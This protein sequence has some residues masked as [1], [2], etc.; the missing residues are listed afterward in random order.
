V[1]RNWIGDSGRAL[2]S[3]CAIFGALQ[4]AADSA[5][6][7]GSLQREYVA[8]T[9]STDPHTKAL[10]AFRMNDLSDQYAHLLNEKSGRYRNPIPD[11]HHLRSLYAADVK[12]ANQY[13][14]NITWCEVNGAWTSASQGY[15]LYL[16]LW[17]NGPAAD[18]AWWRGKFHN[19]IDNCVDAAGTEDETEELIFEY[20]TFL[21]QFPHSVHR[22]E[23]Q[24]LLAQFQS[25]VHKPM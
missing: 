19:Q 14:A 3:L 5:P 20:Q 10:H 9:Q 7:V 21:K 12:Q 1:N 15:L 4:C 18:E 17:P 8:F 16:S 11:L 2:V 6:S 13:G 23:A 22:K 24:A 25:A